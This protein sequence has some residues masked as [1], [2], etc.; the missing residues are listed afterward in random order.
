MSEQERAIKRRLAAITPI[1]LAKREAL[2][3]FN[4]HAL[5][6]IVFLLE[7]LLHTHQQLECAEKALQEAAVAGDSHAQLYWKVFHG[8]KNIT[9]DG[10]E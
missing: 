10:G 8:V 4:E 6:D 5:T 9:R 2:D 3:E 1:W 7:E